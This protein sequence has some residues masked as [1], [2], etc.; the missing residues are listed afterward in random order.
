MLI[1]VSPLDLRSSM[2]DTLPFDGLPEA[3]AVIVSKPLRWYTGRS[4]PVLL[5]LTLLSGIACSVTS[6]TIRCT[7]SLFPRFTVER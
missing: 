1:S 6:S 3:K 7:V 2:S 4:L 5:F